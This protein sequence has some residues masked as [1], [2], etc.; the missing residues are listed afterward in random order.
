MLAA[1]PASPDSPT[2]PSKD[3]FSAPPKAPAKAPPSTTQPKPA[4]PNS[5]SR[6]RKNLNKSLISKC[7]DGRLG[8]CPERSRRVQPSAA[9][10]S[11]P[12]SK[13]A[14][15]QAT[16][17]GNPESPTLLAS[18]P[19]FAYDYLHLD[20][21]GNSIPPAGVGLASIRRKTSQAARAAWHDARSRLRLHENQHSPAARPRGRPL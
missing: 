20:A 19:A 16:P 5:P 2:A 21:D 8:A 17:L 1:K 11:F 6:S 12:A 18:L 3:Y 14:L 15:A 13:R 7:G 10:L 9:R 4:N